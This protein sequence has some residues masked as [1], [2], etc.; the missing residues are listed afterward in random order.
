MQGRQRKAVAV[1]ALNGTRFGL[2]ADAHVHP[3]GGPE[4]PRSVMQAFDSFVATLSLAADHVRVE[5][6]DV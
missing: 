1:Q 4:L 6:V 2:V 5:H 3:G